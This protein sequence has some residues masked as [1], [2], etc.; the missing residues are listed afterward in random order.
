[1]EEEKSLLITKE[2]IGDL[3]FNVIYSIDINNITRQFENDI[4]KVYHMVDNIPSNAFGEECCE[5]ED[6][7]S[8]ARA[9]VNNLENKYFCR[10]AKALKEEV[11]EWIKE[12]E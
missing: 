4:V 12:N 11:E 10:I 5:T 3:F 6:K 8:L 7:S 1:M 2:D 9:L